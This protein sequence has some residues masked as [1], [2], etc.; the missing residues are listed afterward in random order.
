MAL[1]ACI[2]RFVSLGLLLAT[3]SLEPLALV[4]Q[5]ATTRPSAST[6]SPARG[7]AGA[8]LVVATSDAA[9]RIR[10]PDPA[11]APRLW[12]LEFGVPVGARAGLGG[13]FV[14]LGRVAGGT[15]GASFEL[16]E[17]QAEW[18]LQGIV[19]V[20]AW[21]GPRIAL[22]V[23]GGVGA[24]V[25]DRNTTFRSCGFDG[26]AVVCAETL[27]TEDR[28]SLAL[29]AGLEAPVAV[30][31]HVAI[32]VLVRVLSLQRGRFDSPTALRASSLRVMASVSGRVGW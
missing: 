24:L 10:F 15:R 19:R 25:Q 16:N 20:R 31:P 3:G 7:F 2:R 23:A 27:D 28:R 30:A 6:S 1:H 26:R 22:D 17:R 4:A 8:G 12:T 11:T 21:A 5:Q 18:L 13:E 14:S 32:A 9:D 29:S